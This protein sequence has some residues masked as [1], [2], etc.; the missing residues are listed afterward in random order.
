[1]TRLYCF[2]GTSA[3]FLLFFRA[4]RKST[5]KSLVQS[6]PTIIHLHRYESE[7]GDTQVGELPGL[8]GIF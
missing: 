7:I 6:S 1:M 8:P 4:Y 2:I 3:L 5:P